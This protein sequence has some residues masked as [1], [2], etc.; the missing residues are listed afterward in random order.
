MREAIY[1]TAELTLVRDFL[2]HSSHCLIED[3]LNYR[4][5][6]STPSPSLSMRFD[7]TDCLAG[8]IRDA[9][10]QATF[11]DIVARA[12]LCV[13]IPEGKRLVRAILMK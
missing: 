13:I 4:H 5:A 10:Y 6:T 8:S 12:D 11:G 2:S 9:I 3:R 1:N 7:L